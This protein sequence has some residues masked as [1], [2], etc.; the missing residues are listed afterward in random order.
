[1]VDLKV[2][3]DCAALEVSPRVHRW[4]MMLAALC[5]LRRANRLNSR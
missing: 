2:G 3:L 4:A 1:M 5:Y